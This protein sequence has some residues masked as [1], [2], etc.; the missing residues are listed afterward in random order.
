MIHFGFSKCHSEG[1]GCH[2]I[3]FNGD[4]NGICED[5]FMLTQQRG[6]LEALLVRPFLECGNF[7]V[8]LLPLEALFGTLNTGCA[9]KRTGE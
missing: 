6:H 5:E 3:H 2:C 7:P 8:L 4:E 1:F 9:F